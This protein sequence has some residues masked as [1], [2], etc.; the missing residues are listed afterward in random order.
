MNIT[1]IGFIKKELRQTLRDPR[2]RFILFLVPI[3]QMTLCGVALSTEGKNIRL[4]V[5]MAPDD[6]V[7]ADVYRDAI[8]SGWFLPARTGTQDP[9][10]QIQS[11]DADAVLVAPPGG[12][13]R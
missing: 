2:M 10:S 1:L 13:T 7:A 6:T 5:A 4:G 3:V 12:L 8:A 9:F 11:G